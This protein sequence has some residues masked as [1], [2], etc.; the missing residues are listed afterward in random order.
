MIINIL[1]HSL[2][3]TLHFLIKESID[4]VEKIKIYVTVFVVI[5]FFVSDIYIR[6]SFTLVIE[7][8][9][10]SILWAY[11]V[12]GNVKEIISSCII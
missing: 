5:C 7:A 3:H 4:Y 8:K 12:Y 6:I 2:S 9:F 1:I 10:F 11:I